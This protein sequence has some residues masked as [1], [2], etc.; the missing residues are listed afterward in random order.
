MAGSI[1]NY[2]EQYYENYAYGGSYLGTP[3]ITHTLRSLG[4][5]AN[6]LFVEKVDKQTHL[7][8]GC[9]FGVLV[10]T[11]RRLGW[12]SW[13]IDSSEYVISNAVPSVKEYVSVRDAASL[14]DGA[15][16]DESYSV[17][18]CI[19]VL[20]HITKGDAE[21][22]ISAM[23]VL[24]NKFII[25][26]SAQDHEEKTH[27]NVQP[28]SY[29][30]AQFMHNGFVPLHYR[31]NKI[32]W[33]RVYE[34][35]NSYMAL[36]KLLDMETRHEVYERDRF[37]CVICGKSGVQVHEIVPRSAFGRST[38]HT[39]FSVENRVCLCPEH[40]AEAHTIAMR[41]K[42]LRLMSSR[43]GYKY[44]DECFLRYKED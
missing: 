1:N 36:S 31:F 8:V 34:K 28:Q 21:K 35:T 11:M 16:E 25:F 42:L 6:N 18:S 7:D 24:S 5:W 44:E 33:L 40:H 14:L 17:I 15:Q 38:M 4:R 3:A 29:W 19:E 22:A 30:D 32:P 26:S 13:G 39:C 41:R 10:E 20:E 9:A 2:G 12:Y 23:C 43:F 27:I 37:C